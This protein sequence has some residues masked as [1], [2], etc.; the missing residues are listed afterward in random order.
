MTKIIVGDLN[1]KLAAA[2]INVISVR[3]TKAQQIELQFA[4]GVAEA[5]KARAQQ[6]VK[7]YDQDAENAAKPTGL[8]LDEINNAKTVAD[9]KTLLIKQ[10]NLKG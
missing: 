1:N 5:D 9:L 10:H 3:L 6:I 4:D 8:T 7:D 2:G